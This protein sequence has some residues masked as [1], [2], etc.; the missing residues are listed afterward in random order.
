MTG[1]E[2]K[3]LVEQCGTQA[4]VAREL[5]VDAD[6]IRARYRD[7]TVPPLYEFAIIGMLYRDKVAE[8]KA[9]PSVVING[10]EYVPRV[11]RKKQTTGRK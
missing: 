9:T 2:F 11:E 6:T 8:E 5:G 1:D 3:Q 4:A 10:V 7:A